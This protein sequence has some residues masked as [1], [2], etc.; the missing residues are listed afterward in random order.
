MSAIFFDVMNQ[1]VVSM[2]RTLEEQHRIVVQARPKSMEW[3]RMNKNSE[4][5]LVRVI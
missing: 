3:S 1:P 2:W 4:H 5:E